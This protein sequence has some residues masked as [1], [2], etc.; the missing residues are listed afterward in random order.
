MQSF[1]K[2]ALPAW[3]PPDPAAG[4]AL[5]FGEGVEMMITHV[6]PYTAEVRRILWA[7]QKG[8]AIFV[9]TKGRMK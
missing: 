7:K 4:E 8:L 9:Q 2:A 3:V 6:A 5:R 1:F